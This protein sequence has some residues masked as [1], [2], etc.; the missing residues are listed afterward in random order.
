MEDIHSSQDSHLPVYNIKAV[1]RIVGLR[2]VTLRA[3]ERRYGIPRPLRGDQGY[4][5]Y[6]EHD[7]RTLSWL[8]Y[9][10]DS[11]MNIS[12]AV[13]Y[14]IE[15]RA[16]GRD[17]VIEALP[18]IHDNQTVSL[19]HLSQ[20]L[21]EAL[22]RLDAAS[23]NEIMRRAFT[24]YSVD[25]VLLEVIEPVQIEIGE[26][27]HAGKLSIAVEH[28]ATQFFLQHLM[29]M[30][31]ASA[32]ISHSGVIIAACAPG[33]QHQIGLLVIVV[34][35]RWRGWDVRYL[36]PDLQIDR[37]EEALAPLHPRMLLFTATRE[38]AAR[39]LQKMPE[40]LQRFPNPKPLVVLGGQAFLNNASQDAPSPG[41]ILNGRPPEMIASLEAL[42]LRAAPGE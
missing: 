5:L 24:L 34:M 28:Y 18:T 2:P 25:Q 13:N 12:Q 21:L 19:S 17:P 1:A 30:L 39:E 14:L 11:G 31:N 4:R 6:S 15:L 36:G 29:G 35:L 41:I 37:M 3:W 23:A 32:S 10:V 20:R 22:I 8:K 27:W 9:Q 16:K 42:L 33:E 40:I 7:V 26:Q 38:S